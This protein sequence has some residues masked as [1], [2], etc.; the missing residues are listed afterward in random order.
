M[1][2]ITKCAASFEEDGVHVSIV[3]HLKYGEGLR[4]APEE[5][6]PTPPRSAYESLNAAVDR[7]IY[8]RAV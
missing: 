5:V 4:L 6:A 8:I 2:V 1:A 3:A 7:Y